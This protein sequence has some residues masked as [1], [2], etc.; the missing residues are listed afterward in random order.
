MLQ[1][2]KYKMIFSIPV[3]ERPD[4][5][6]DQ[7]INIS[8]HNED[9]GIVL[10]ISKAFTDNNSSVSLQ[11][12]YAFVQKM[13]NVVINSNQYNT[14]WGHIVHTH[15]ANYEYVCNLTDFDYFTLLASN[16][17]FVRKGFYDKAKEFECGFKYQ[18]LQELKDRWMWAKNT[19]DDPTVYKI[20]DNL[21]SDYDDI[22][23]SQLEGIFFSKTLFGEICKVIKKSFDINTTPELIYPREEVYYQ[24]AAYFLMEDKK[25]IFNGCMTFN[26]SNNTTWTPYR[27]VID[28]VASGIYPEF[29][30]KR[31]G[32]D[33]NNPTRS[34]IRRHYGNYLSEVQKYVPDAYVG[35]DF[36]LIRFDAVQ[37]MIDYAHRVGRVG[38]RILKKS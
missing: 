27:N 28:K 24:E 37:K 36:D 4:V 38:K 16:E 22:V 7:I 19:L 26:A 34:Y 32:R 13:P 5:I 31:V 25:R 11:Q 33:I 3:H 15:I 21:S 20:A 17:L 12:L 10:H 29:S 23:R 30:V 2:K 35:R 6:I 9:C 1:K 14:A 8:V 18:K